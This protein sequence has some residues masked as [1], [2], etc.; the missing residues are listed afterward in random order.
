ML[1]GVR[2]MQVFIFIFYFYMKS[3]IDHLDHGLRDAFIF[4]DQPQ[5]AL[6]ESIANQPR[7]VAP[8]PTAN[9]NNGL[10]LFFS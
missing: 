10:T 7:Q 1:T 6:R 4:L 8:Q 2:I 3:L 5:M 9:I